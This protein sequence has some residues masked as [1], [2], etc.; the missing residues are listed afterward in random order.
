MPVVLALVLPG[1]NFVANNELTISAGEML[2]RWMYASVFLYILWFLQDFVWRSGGKF[3]WLWALVAALGMAALIYVVLW[4]LKAEMPNIP[5]VQLTLKIISASVLILVIR[6]AIE[7][8]ASVQHLQVE[9]E[10]ILLEKYRVQ[11]QELRTRVDPHFLFNTLNTLRTMIRKNHPDAERF[12]MNLSS[13]YRQTL[14][15]NDSLT[16]TLREEMDVLH[17]YLFLMQ[18]RN[19]GAIQTEI[20]I[21]PSWQD[22]LLPAMSLQ[23][24]TEN[25]FKHN[26]VSPTEPLRLEIYTE[27]DGYVV[28]RN[29]L[30]K[31]F[32]LTQPSGYGHNNISRAYALLNV[33][34][35]LVVNKTDDF[36][37]VRLKL[38]RP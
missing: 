16:L 1:L 8:G 29:N 6:Y 12:V 36:F 10:Q 24:M 14:T 32:T 2:K 21:D 17:S 15:F 5:K 18:N 28:V 7:A 38:I 31:R 27:Q 9:K 25:C 11:L 30:L 13:L 22:A 34:G 33:E 26:R 4:V 23:V 19:E 35:G 20:N 37:E 3:R